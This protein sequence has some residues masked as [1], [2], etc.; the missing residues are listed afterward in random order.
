MP[1]CYSIPDSE[2]FEVYEMTNRTV[3]NNSRNH[4][5]DDFQLRRLGKNP[6]LK[7]NFNA[8]SLVGLNCIVL[9][10][11]EMV[12]IGG[13]A[14]FLSAYFL[15]WIGSLCTVIMIGEL[16]SMA[17]IS[18]S[19]YHWCA[20]LAPSKW[21]R[22]LSYI[23]MCTTIIAWKMIVC[24]SYDF[25]AKIVQALIHFALPSTFTRA[26]WKE[27][28]IGLGIQILACIP[29]VIGGR[30]LPRLQILALMVHI[31][32]FFAILI[33]VSYMPEHREAQELFTPFLNAGHF[34]TP[35]LTWFF[36]M[37]FYNGL[38]MG[39]CCAVHLAE[40]SEGATATLG[41]TMIISMILDG[42]LGFGM[43]IALLFNKQAIEIAAVY[44]VYS[45][46]IL[47]YQTTNSRSATIILSCVWVVSYMGRVLACIAPASR[48][49]WS[50]ARDQGIPGWK[51][52]KK[53]SSNYLPTNATI[54]VVIVSILINLIEL[55]SPDTYIYIINSVGPLWCISYTIIG[56]LL[57]YRRYK[58]QI[59]S[60]GSTDD[61]MINVPGAK[62]VWGPFRIPG[63]WGILIN[64]GSIVY[65]IVIFFSQCLPWSVDKTTPLQRFLSSSVI[66][67]MITV[68]ILVFY[69]VRARKQYKGPI[70]EAGV[71]LAD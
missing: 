17:P 18:A 37:S 10:T 46:I 48:Q 35:P 63:I 71:R 62:L 31:L 26:V 38:F 47:F 30:T 40:E 15:S 19:Q 57:L 56:T 39:G 34:P 25:V 21:M 23:T 13:P 6:A 54:F 43:S 16:A 24:Q 11:W 2:D 7:R 28:L 67:I 5:Q 9:M 29:N 8:I 70:A 20:M 27:K 51:I 22:P 53:V 42:L 66:S 50:L 69:L 64:F 1:E 61:P 45:P 36:V 52:L 4:D 14:S 60:Y 59:L 44:G 58:G 41:P 65:S 49:V 3:Y 33:P 32:G 68:F 55:G 12:V